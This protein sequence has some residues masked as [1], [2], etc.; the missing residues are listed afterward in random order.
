MVEQVETPSDEASKDTQ[1]Q[2]D[3]LNVLDQFVDLLLQSQ[4]QTLYQSTPVTAPDYSVSAGM[5]APAIHQFTG[6]QAQSAA[7]TPFSTIDGQ[8]LLNSAS[9]AVI[10]DTLGLFGDISTRSVQTSYR[11]E[12]RTTE[13]TDI[14]KIAQAQITTQNH[15]IYHIPEKLIEKDGTIIQAEYEA[16]SKGTPSDPVLTNGNFWYSWH[17]TETYGLNV[18]TVWEE[19]TGSGIK[20]AV[21]DDGVNRTHSELSTNYDTSLDYDTLDDDSDAISTT[22][23]DSHGTH[24]SMV[25]AA[26]DNGSQSLGVAYDST[27]IGI[28]RGYGADSSGQDTLEGFEHVETVDADIMNNSWGSTAAFGDHKDLNFVGVDPSASHSQILTLIQDG[29]SGLGTNI[30]FSAGNDQQ[31][32][33]SANYKNYQNSPYTIAVGASS[34]DGTIADFSEWGANVLL[35]APGDDIRVPYTLENYAIDIDGTSFSAPAVSGIIAL[36]LEAN[37]DLGYRD[38]QEILA[39]SARQT[40]LTHT[41]WNTNA[42]THWN[43]GGMTF[44]HNY[45]YGIADAYAAVR[46]AETW[47]KQQT[48]SN[49]LT[50]SQFDGSNL[51]ISS[52]GTV[53][54]TI[55]VTENIE[56]EHVLIDLDIDHTRAGDLIITLISPEGTESILV[57]RIDNGTFTSMFGIKDGFFFEFSSVAHWGETSAGTWTLQIEDAVSGNSGTLNDWDLQFVGHTISTDDTYVYTED[58]SL[59][60]GNLGDRSALEDTNGGIDTLN[61]SSITSGSTINLL[62]GAATLDDQSVTISGIE[63]VY[64]GDGDDTLTGNG[65]DNILWGGRGADVIDGGDGDDTASWLHDIAEYSFDLADTTISVI[66]NAVTD[67]V[68]NVENFIFDG[69]SY[70]RSEIIGFIFDEQGNNAPVLTVSDVELDE[71][72]SIL[73]SSIISAVDDDGHTLAYTIND[74]NTDADSA[75]FELDN[76][77]LTAGQDY[78]LTAEEFATLRI[79][80]GSENGTDDFTIQVSD[81]GS[82]DTET[83]TVTTAIINLPPTLTGQAAT[84]NSNATILASSIFTAND[85]DT[86]TYMVYDSNNNANSAYFE[87]S[88]SQLDA[89]TMYTL[90][91]AQFTA[92]NIV[93]GD[94]DFSEKLW[95]KVSDGTY[96]TSWVSAQVTTADDATPIL[97][98]QDITLRGGA[99][100]LA[101][102]Y[103]SAVD[104][105]TENEDFSYII[106]DGN[107]DANSGYFE[108]NGVQLNA[109]QNYTLTHLELSNLHIVAGQ[110]SQ[111]DALSISVSDGNTTSNASTLTLTTQ[112]LPTLTVADIQLASGTTAL[113]SSVISANDTD[114]DTL[115]YYVLD[116][117]ASASSG[118][119]EL[120]STELAA[121]NRYTLTAAEFSNLLIV[122]G[123]ADSYDNLW[124]SVSDGTNTTKWEGLR[125]TTALNEAPTLLTND[126][127]LE[128]GKEIF[129]SSLIIGSDPDDD[130]LTYTLNDGNADAGSATLLYNG[131]TLNANQDYSFS[132]AEFQ[133]VRIISGQSAGTDV[134]SVQVSDGT[135]SSALDS[136]TI[137]TNAFN[138]APTITTANIT[139]SEGSNFDALSA[140]SGIDADGDTLGYW[141]YDSSASASSAY[142]SLD[143]SEFAAKQNIFVASD[144]IDRLLIIGGSADVTERFLVRASDGEKTS[145]WE[146]FNV[147]TVTGDTIEGGSVADVVS[148]NDGD[149]TIYGHDGD[150]VLYGLDGLD[151]LIGGLGSDTFTFLTDSA[152]NDLDVI[153]DFK[154]SQGDAIDISDLL[155]DF[156][157]DQDAINDFIQITDNGSDSTISIDADGGANNFQAVATIQGVTGLTDEQTLLDNGNLIA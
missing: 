135:L 42:D 93:G 69:V 97:Q 102:N 22:E 34:T 47:T 49:A 66:R 154:T 3:T 127:T 147:K 117:S 8:S 140:F 115:T 59:Y 128:R 116:A 20:V 141:V 119:F 57:D 24:V 36:M 106:N 157:P 1:E 151:N 19:Y 54:T 46:I 73:A 52:I 145:G 58:F 76:T 96:N 85:S 17:L 72:E 113:A 111:T 142:F 121:N 67:L 86:L 94:D 105:D 136:L 50:S 89:N 33:S 120:S 13:N 80:G 31:E 133:H 38:V 71:A 99:S 155:I 11:A 27:I 87:L 90:N 25:I 6:I 37:P 91:E 74:T 134:I 110:T 83:V 148:G 10:G 130:S 139:I 82:S 109:E 146:R 126:T 156:D 150:D 107:A 45:G 16:F 144:D 21:F 43:G 138:N 123:S 78:T 68:T 64:T 51:N 30:V 84:I 40:D 131:V 153:Q 98:L 23:A 55:N 103:I 101:Y 118:Y 149:N 35:S 29:R 137:T 18:Q 122:G 39:I 104:S 92:L 26:D 41:G 61:A 112:A 143:G 15:I 129:A 7:S 32:G 48:Y 100:V 28:R 75:Y 62:T 152:F 125:L 108:L 5:D 2:G 77:E 12:F 79:V 81:G 4:N 63:N 9:D 70:L 60:S 53:S 44:N 56:I 124:I 88:G 114:G 132:A 95:V 14:Y 65:S